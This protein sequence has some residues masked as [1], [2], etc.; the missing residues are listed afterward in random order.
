MECIESLGARLVLAFHPLRL[1]LSC[2]SAV[3]L[4][5]R[6]WSKTRRKG[7]YPASADDTA[8]IVLP[9]LLP[10]EFSRSC[11]MDEARGLSFRVLIS[12]RERSGI[13]I[14]Y[15]PD[16]CLGPAPFAFSRLPCDFIRRDD[17]RFLSLRFFTVSLA[18]V[19]T[20]R[21]RRTDVV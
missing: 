6:I 15:I 11:V 16:T 5:S 8:E 13:G 18:V 1:R 20:A 14:T 9:L 10:C 3:I 4:G 2:V 7:G 17:A 21:L 19:S 12:T